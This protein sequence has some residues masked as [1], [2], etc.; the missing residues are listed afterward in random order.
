MK[1]K[2]LAYL[3]SKTFDSEGTLKVPNI[4]LK[5]QRKYQELCNKQIIGTDLYFSEAIETIELSL[6][7]EGGKVKSEALLATRCLALA[8]NDNKARHFI[9]DK[10]FA[11]FLIDKT[12][13]I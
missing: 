9:F 2:E 13:N 10:T 7:N 11:M 1:E 12:C 4:N 5:E 8:P 6:N 3:G